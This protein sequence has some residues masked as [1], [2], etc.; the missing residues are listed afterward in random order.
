MDVIEQ[1]VAF[2]ASLD[3]SFAARLQGDSAED[4]SRLEATL[5]RPLN[6]QHHSFLERMGRGRAW[7]DLGTV[8]CSASGLRRAYEVTEGRPPPGMELFATG[9]EELEVDV[10]LDARRGPEPR[11]VG[12]DRVV[13]DSF[14][15]V[16][17]AGADVLAGSLPEFL[18]LKALDTYRF[19]TAPFSARFAQPREE[20]GAL[21]RLDALCGA[22]GFQ[23]LWFS[24]DIARVFLFGQTHVVA[25]Q[26]PRARLTAMVVGTQETEHVLISRFL[27]YTQGLERTP[28]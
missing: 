9:Q 13:G 28:F 12:L 3:D 21:E 25:R 20:E 23:R 27:A 6:P 10:F 26:L 14:E 18:C 24:S 19:K 1:V 8:D 7:L 15:G 22:L 4:I 11:V 2:I 16:E 17:T 5:G